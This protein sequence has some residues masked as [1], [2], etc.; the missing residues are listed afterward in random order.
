MSTKRKVVFS[1]TA[2]ALFAIQS[3]WNPALAQTTAL[4]D[5]TF[6]VKDASVAN[7]VRVFQPGNEDGV[8]D[9]G[10]GTP[11]VRRLPPNGIWLIADDSQKSETTTSTSTATPTSTGTS[12]ASTSTSTPRSAGTAAASSSSGSSSSS[13]KS[14]KTSTSAAAGLWNNNGSLKQGVQGMLLGHAF[15]IERG[16]YNSK[17][18]VL[19]QG[20]IKGGR[21]AERIAIIF[22]NATTL[23]NSK[24]VV[25]NWQAQLYMPRQ[26]AVVINP[27]IITRAV[28]TERT[29][30]N[31][32]S[33]GNYQMTLQFFSSR[34]GMLPGY[35]DLRVTNERTAIKGYFFLTKC[36]DSTSLW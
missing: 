16:D 34:N 33:S 22:P 4:P 27:L 8:A 5:A 2:S 15:K 21:S 20:Q 6:N 26:Q 10:I 3:L 7:A 9:W 14:A 30:I 23:D 11:G 35:I 19:R 25:V 13:W 24:Y 31:T 32:G 17:S 18:I 12:T 36:E 29:P 1:V 28:N